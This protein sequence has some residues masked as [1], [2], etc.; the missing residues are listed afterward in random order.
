M[1]EGDVL[2]LFVPLKESLRN[3]RLLQRWSSSYR[4]V[5][6]VTSRGGGFIGSAGPILAV[7]PDMEDLGKIAGAGS[8]V[9]ALCVAAWVEKWVS[10]WV[11]A[12]QAEILSDSQVW[13]DITAP[14]MDPVVR[15]AMQ[16]LTLTINHN[17]TIA[18][19]YEKDQVVGV[20]LMLHGA[21]YELDG[22]QLQ[23]WALA[24]G[25]GDK[26]P[27]HLAKY[28]NEIKR[29]KRPRVRSILRSDYL[30]YLRRKVAS[31]GADGE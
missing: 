21:G 4:D 11:A 13:E 28:V 2:T 6:V 15:E 14:A 9:R 10:P 12:T 8:Y 16:G 18:A 27:Q 20:L 1:Q 7:W 22:E 29:G 24:H 25:W 5:D 17:N 3:G 23:V 26:N 30:D 31:E 19:G